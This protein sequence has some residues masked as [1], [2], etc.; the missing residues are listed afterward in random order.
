MILRKQSKGKITTA[1][2]L[3]TETTTSAEIS[4]VGYNSLLV[5]TSITDAVQNWT[6]KV[7][8][9]MTSGGTFADWYD[10]ATQMSYQTNSG[11]AAV[12]KGVPDFCRIVATED[13]NGA[14]CTVKVQPLNT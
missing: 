9:C 13:V 10:G 2:S 12:W 6:V 11:K 14:K 1:H 4:C 7:Q 3:I 8:G 5:Y